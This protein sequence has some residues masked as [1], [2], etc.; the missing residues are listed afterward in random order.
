M[1]SILLSLALF[2]V[3]LT[4]RAQQSP[5][6]IIAEFFGEY[7]SLPPAVAL[8]NLYGHMPWVERIR[9]SVEKLKTQFTDLQ[10]LV[11]DYAGHDLIAEKDVADRFVVYSYLVRFD[12][13]PVRFLFQFYK[14]GDTWGLYSF[15][16]D[17][18]LDIELEDAVKL[19]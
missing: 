15:S 5:E 11:G 9:D 7:E 14:P 2:T 1:K 18:Q 13:Q 10:N 19:K 4:G 16:Y 17:D 6:Q 8:E 12:R 3:V